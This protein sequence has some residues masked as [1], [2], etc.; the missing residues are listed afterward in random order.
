VWAIGPAKGP[1]IVPQAEREPRSAAAS[2]ALLRILSAPL[3]WWRSSLSL[4]VVTL[5]VAGTAV[6]LVVAGILLVHQ[7]TGEVLAQARQ[8]ALSDANEAMSLIEQDL[9][10]AGEEQVGIHV[11][12]SQITL[13]A[14]QRG[15]VSGRYEVSFESDTGSL[16]TPGFDSASIPDDLRQAVASDRLAVH[17]VATSVRHIGEDEAAPGFIVASTVSGAGSSR[18]PVYFVFP[19]IEEERT[20]D[21]FQTGAVVSALVL[22]IGMGLVA[23]GMAWQTVQPIR[24]ARQAAERL[25]SGELTQPMPV[26]GVD[27]LGRLALSMNHMAEQL[28][29]RIGQL[30]QL[31]H[32][33]QRFVSD[34]SHELRTPLTTVRM[35]ADVLYDRRDVFPDPIETR[36]AVLLHQ[37]VS[38][39]ESLLADLLEIS[40]FDAGAAVLTLDDADLS[41]LLTSEVDSLRGVAEAAGAPLRFHAP[42]G[43]CVAQVDSRR[44]TRIMRNLI[45]NAIEHA[46]GNPIDITLAG[47]DA[48]VAFTVRDHGVGFSRD[49]GRQLF[50]R[51]WR[52]DPARTRR[53]GGTGLGLAI[54]QEDV[55]L[56]E[57]WIHAWG[58]VGQGAQF[59]VTLPRVGGQPVMSSPLPLIPVDADQADVLDV[60]VAGRELIVGSQA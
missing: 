54:T 42:P 55:R 11:I 1:D 47:D 46:N 53:I 43:R 6:V 32:L 24:A 44:V 56:H 57:G 39:F 17:T 60:S 16:S 2:G 52:G 36:S 25:A 34:V 7:V 50:N 37:E 49:E 15:Q 23:Y 29:Q 13:S 40:R 18:Y 30:E 9:W 4:R 10:A 38:R 8:S 28:Q 58:R 45:S 41:E 14:I 21:L 19:F 51:F 33:Q 12:P 31:S 48:V 35:A 3:D 59:R 26:R 27:D 5:S 22:L 20:L